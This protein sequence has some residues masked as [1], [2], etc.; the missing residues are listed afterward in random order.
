[1]S[2]HDH[3]EIALSTLRAMGIEPSEFA[4]RLTASGEEHSEHTQNVRDYVEGS[5]LAGLSKGK[6][7]TWEP[8][9]RFFIE[10][11]DKLCA[12]FC[13]ECLDYFAGNSQWKPCPCVTQGT[14]S[15][16]SDKL[17]VGSVRARSC[18][19]HCA[20]LGDKALR[21]IKKTDLA[22]MAN[23][24]QLRA[25]KRTAR[26]N[27]NRSGTGR[28]TFPYDGRS[29]LELFRAATSCIYTLAIDDAVPGVTRNLAL[30]LAVKARPSAV[31]RAYSDTQVEELWQAVFSSGGDDTQLDMLL[32][33]FLFETGSRRGGPIGMRV[34]DLLFN[35]MKVRLSEKNGKVDEQPVSPA[36]M[37]AL[38][39]HALSRGEV[40]LSN[41]LSLGLDEINMSHVIARQVTLRTDEQVFYYKKPL[42]T[43]KNPNP[44]PHPLTVRKFD[45]LWRRLKKDLPWL[46]EIHGRPHDLRK[47]SATYIERAFG[48][49]V[50]KAFLRHSVNGVTDLYTA[51]SGEEV[52]RAHR[53]L[54][55]GG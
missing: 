43:A 36:L 42:S 35:S 23:W 37:G 22:T 20:G 6:R 21:D 5:V 14:C 19:E 11:Y 10:G 49:S 45:S 52:E 51:S 39:T 53:H 15:C 34:G 12:C 41:P 28:S 47:T 17:S 2:D 46:D 9:I 8:Y 33:W 48:H 27:L 29:A 40:L 25:Q 32:V 55:G 31:A 16:T 1:M 3:F 26:R 44:Q 13:D 24:A 18:L 38:L 4:A 7:K 50:A 30:T 54:I